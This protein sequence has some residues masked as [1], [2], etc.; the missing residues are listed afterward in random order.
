MFDIAMP[1]FETD[2]VNTG[3][4]SA[5]R[6]ST[7]VNPGPCSNLI[8]ADSDGALTDRT[9]AYGRSRRQRHAIGAAHPRNSGPR[10]AGWSS[11]GG[12]SPTKEVAP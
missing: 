9:A 5:V 10:H 11:D 2:D 12:L 4:A 6:A 1:L 3:L 7:P 8:V